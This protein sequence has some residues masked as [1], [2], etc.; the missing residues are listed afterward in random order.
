MFV[1]I[2][3]YIL[4]TATLPELQALEDASHRESRLVPLVKALHRVTFIRTKRALL[5]KD[6]SAF[7][8]RVAQ[9]FLECQTDDEFNIKEQVLS[10]VLKD[11]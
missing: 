5:V 1:E 9:V 10:F 11:R 4:H 3:G 8:L 2:V 6:H 7:A